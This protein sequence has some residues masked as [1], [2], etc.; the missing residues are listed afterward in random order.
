MIFL[1]K[2]TDMFTHDN[3]E[4]MRSAYGAAMRIVDD[5]MLQA[6]NDAYSATSR[7]D[8]IRL[9]MRALQIA[10]FGSSLT[11]ILFEGTN[12]IRNLNRYF[13]PNFPMPEGYVIEHRQNMPVGDNTIVS[14][15]WCKKRLG[16][17]MC[18]LSCTDFD[19]RLD[20]YSGCFFPELKLIK[21]TNGLHHLALAK[22]KDQ[23]ALDVDVYPLSLCFPYFITDGAYWINNKSNT[24]EP[25]KEMRFAILYELARELWKESL[26]EGARNLST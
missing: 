2:L 11:R 8:V 1:K 14:I 3:A 25:V 5:A 18:H 13:I 26:R 17:A 22:L 15:P 6:R 9:F 24:K 10:L 20:N 19:Y 21:V 23:G 12:D 4:N 16:G 7:S